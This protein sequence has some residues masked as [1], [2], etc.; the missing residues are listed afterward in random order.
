MVVISVILVPVSRAKLI[1]RTDNT[2]FRIKR[3]KDFNG[4]AV[5]DRL[6]RLLDTDDLVRRAKLFYLRKL[7]GK[8]ARIKERK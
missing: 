3:H 4:C 2:L 8:A 6:L 5:A 7:S 1:H